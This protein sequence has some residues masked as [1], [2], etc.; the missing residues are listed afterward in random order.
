MWVVNLLL[1]APGK[2][3]LYCDQNT[4]N[5]FLDWEHTDLILAAE[6]PNSIL[7]CGGGFEVSIESVE[8]CVFQRQYASSSKIAETLCYN[9]FMFSSNEEVRVNCKEGSHIL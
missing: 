3:T 6:R 9:L 4:F 2:W 5:Q 8:D 7:L 1:T